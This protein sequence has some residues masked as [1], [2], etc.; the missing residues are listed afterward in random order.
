[1]PWAAHRIAD[2]QPFGQWPVIVAAVRRH[3][4]D[5]VASAYQQDLVAAGVTDQHAAV[6]EIGQRDSHGEVGAVGLGVV[7]HVVLP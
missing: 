1:M 6:G 5:L 3:G 2:Q 7:C 4:E